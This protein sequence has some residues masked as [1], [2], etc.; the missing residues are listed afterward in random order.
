MSTDIS[1]K[2]YAISPD[3]LDRVV[4]LYELHSGTFHQ[5]QRELMK[6]EPDEIKYNLAIAYGV[7]LCLQEIFNSI[8]EEQRHERTIWQHTFRGKPGGRGEEGSRGESSTNS[9]S[10]GKSGQSFIT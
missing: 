10:K 9:S 5:S 1:E 7:G 8:P 3:L 6:C 4:H 2:N